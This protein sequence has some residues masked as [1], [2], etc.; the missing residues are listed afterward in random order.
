MKH[1]EF[2]NIWEKINY[3]KKIN[4]YL[5]LMPDGDS[6][7]SCV[8]LKYILSNKD[9][10]II[11]DDPLPGRLA[12]CEF[13]KE[14][15]YIDREAELYIYP[16]H[17]HNMGRETKHP[18]IV[19]D[20]HDKRNPFGE[21]EY[22]KSWPSCAGLL[23]N[24]YLRMNVEIPTG[25]YRAFYIGIVTDTGNATF[26]NLEERQQ[27][28]DDIA[29]CDKVANCATNTYNKTFYGLTLEQNKW[30]IDKIQ[31]GDIGN[32][33]FSLIIK[34]TESWDSTNI[35]MMTQKISE[36]VNVE[37]FIWCYDTN[38]G[39]KFSIRTGTIDCLE[40][41]KRYVGG[42]GDKAAASFHTKNN[43]VEVIEE[44]KNYVYNNKT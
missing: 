27:A 9:V 8:G 44:F 32:N 13:A 28:R 33:I 21:I 40:F 6:L 16:D 3:H 23:L 10:S 41:V 24:E 31:D 19:I 5:H 18:S 30:V 36:K 1:M 11:S 37:N 34:D 15:S 29:L 7:S 2:E 42:G 4:I 17:P 35:R 43:P 22:V 38:A 26:G 20:H 14:V 25:A 39:M 12:T